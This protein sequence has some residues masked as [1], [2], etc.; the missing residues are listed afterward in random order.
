MII[1]IIDITQIIQYHKD[2]KFILNGTK[3]IY[4][5]IADEIKRIFGRI[6]FKTSKKRKSYIFYI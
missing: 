4:K 2:M 5:E 3:D 1:S 6:I